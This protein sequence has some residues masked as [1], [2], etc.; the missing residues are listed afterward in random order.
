MPSSSA[1]ILNCPLECDK[2]FSR[3]DALAK[4]MRQQHGIAPPPPGRGGHK[5]K[6]AESGAVSQSTLTKMEIDDDQEMGLI[7]E[8]GSAVGLPPDDR[9][10]H[11]NDLSDISEDDIPPS[12]QGQVDPATG[13]I[14]GRSPSMVKYLVM[15]A[16]YRYILAEHELLLDELEMLQREETRLTQ[17]KDQALDQLLLA[18]F[19]PSAQDFIEDNRVE[20]GKA[21]G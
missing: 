21:H 1:I 14:L 7:P 15:K 4:H 5:R 17:S 8:P 12:L 6:R 18:E 2:T 16:K 19:G 3:S 20:V 13:L 10:V 9:I 11:Q